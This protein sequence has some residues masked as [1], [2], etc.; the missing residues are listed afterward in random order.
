[1]AKTS[2]TAA[3]LGGDMTGGKMPA[4]KGAKMPMKP[5]KPVKKGGKGKK[6]C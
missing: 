5:A 3:F 1:M 4:A 2:K 6:K